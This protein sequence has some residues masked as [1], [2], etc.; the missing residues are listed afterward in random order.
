M[1][2]PCAGRV[3]LVGY[4]LSGN[5]GHL[6]SH[7]ASPARATFRPSLPKLF[8]WWTSRCSFCASC[9]AKRSPLLLHRNLAPPSTPP[10]PLSNKDA[11]GQVQ[12]VPTFRPD[13]EIEWCIDGVLP[14]FSPL[15]RGVGVRGEGLVC[16]T[17]RF[18][19]LCS[20]PVA[21]GS[22]ASAN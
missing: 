19:L 22:L 4:S 15:G 13:W 12:T 16:G 8:L 5:P 6:D 18:F 14:P 17:R 11:R 2:S 3:V 1:V 7:P 10:A 9:C 20:K 21:C